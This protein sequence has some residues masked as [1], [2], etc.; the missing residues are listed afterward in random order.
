MGGLIARL[1]GGAVTPLIDQAADYGAGLLRKLALFLVAAICVAIAGA[2]ATVA[3]G[4]WIASFAGAVVGAAAVAGV[5]LLLGGACV[6]LAFRP[7]R[8]I[9]EAA[10]VAVDENEDVEDDEGR[11]R[12]E[13]IDRFT[14]PLLRILSS[15]GLRREQIA[16]LAGASI[17][18]QLKPLP[19]LGAAIV[20]GFVIGR[21]YKG[22]RGLL[23]LES[24]AAILSTGLF[25]NFGKEATQSGAEP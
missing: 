20:A 23:S 10:K 8:R 25:G 4:L 3:F 5:Y 17:A 7:H 24:L 12:R 13:Q 22:W 9:S 15:L 19:L 18:K 16:V 1:I 11:F 21:M 2:A 6:G 14:E